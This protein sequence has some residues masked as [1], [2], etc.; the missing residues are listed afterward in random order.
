MNVMTMAVLVGVVNVLLAV[1]LVVQYRLNRHRGF[2]GLGW[3]A[4]GQAAVA[5]GLGLSAV[6]AASGVGHAAIPVYQ[7]LLVVGMSSIVVGLLRFMGR[8]ERVGRLVA[9]L[10]VFV[11]WS[12][13]FTWVND[14]IVLR[15]VGLYLAIGT[16]DAWAAWALVRHGPAAFRAT[17]RATGAVFGVG[18]RSTSRWRLSG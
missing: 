8:R 9:A 4:V 15:S 16:L 1:V 13:Y 6:R 5:V 17:A 14:S 3:W 2:A 18:L 10:A 11:A 7:G 12:A